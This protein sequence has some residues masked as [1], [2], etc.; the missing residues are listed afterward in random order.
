MYK[1][2]LFDLLFCGFVLYSVVMVTHFVLH[3]HMLFC[4]IF[5]IISTQYSIPFLLINAREE[6]KLNR[7]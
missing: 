7:V 4:R 6:T 5:C 1:I 3:I 2:K